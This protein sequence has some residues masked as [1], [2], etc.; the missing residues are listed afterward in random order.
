[1]AFTTVP[2]AY[3][4]TPLFPISIVPVASFCDNV[5]FEPIIAV[6][7]SP[8]VFKMLLLCISVNSPT[9]PAIP[10]PVNSI[11]PLFVNLTLSL[12]ES[13]FD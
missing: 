5:P 6:E 9:I 10:V 13:E 1:L 8:V 7:L 12:K 11:V 2:S 3:I 4:P